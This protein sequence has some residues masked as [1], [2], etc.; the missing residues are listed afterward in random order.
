MKDIVKEYEG[1][2]TCF[3]DW[4][5]QPLLVISF[6]LSIPLYSCS[7]RKCVKFKILPN[8]YKSLHTPIMGSL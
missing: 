7:F 4:V 8:I 3:L 6:I 5:L 2:N 1:S